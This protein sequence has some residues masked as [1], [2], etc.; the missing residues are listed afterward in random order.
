MGLRRAV[1]VNAAAAYVVRGRAVFFGCETSISSADIA[2]PSEL[3][4]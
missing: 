1:A 4:G 3:A 2:S